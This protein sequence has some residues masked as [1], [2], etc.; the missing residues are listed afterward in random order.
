MLPKLFRRGMKKILFA[1]IAAVALLGAGCASINAQQSPSAENNNAVSQ[2]VV[3]E[4]TV[5]ANEF[6]FDPF[7]ITIK[8]GEQVRLI[9]NNVGKY[10]HNWVVDELNLKTA[11]I[12]GGESTT[13]EFTADK[14][15]TFPVYCSIG[16]HRAKG[17]EGKIIVEE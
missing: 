17:M 7:N 8:K 13:L 6:S 12:K 11:T 16:T 3:K 2:N 14:A 4:I 15:G 1:M 5:Q 10:P 9:L